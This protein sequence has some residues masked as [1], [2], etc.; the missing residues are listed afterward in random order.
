[1]A[2]AVLFALAICLALFLSTSP[3]HAA[4]GQP[5]RFGPLT[6][7]QK[8]ELELRAV[9]AKVALGVL[10]AF[11]TLGAVGQVVFSIRNFRRAAEENGGKH[12]TTRTRWRRRTT[13]C[14]KACRQSSKSKNRN[15]RSRSRFPRRAG[16]NR[17]GSLPIKQQPQAGD[18]SS[19][20]RVPTRQTAESIWA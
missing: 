10:A 14:F 16:K 1:M 12:G 2:R 13:Q 20:P 3:V 19:S 5:N 9:Y 11:L 8:R 17:A 18:E 6:P 15:A 4:H 7:E